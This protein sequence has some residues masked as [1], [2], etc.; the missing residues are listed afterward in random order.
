MKPFST[1]SPITLKEIAQSL[2]EGKRMARSIENIADTFAPLVDDSDEVTRER[3]S[4]L[5]SLSQEMTKII[6]AMY[7]QIAR[8]A[9]AAGG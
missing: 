3:L 7:S 6:S 2:L 5:A 1:V 4:Q 9:M 8:D